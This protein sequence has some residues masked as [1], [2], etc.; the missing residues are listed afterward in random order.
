MLRALSESDRH[1]MEVVAQVL[2]FR[3]NRYVIERLIDH[4]RVPDDPIFRMT[5]PH[6]DMLREEDFATIERL[7][8]GGACAAEVRAAASRIRARLNPHP[9]DQLVQNI[10]APG[11]QHKYRDTVLVFPRQGQTC[12]SYCGYCFRWAQFT[13]EP[14]L[15]I[16]TDETT[17]VA[18][19]VSAHPEVRSVLFTG[20][21][22]M[23]MRTGALRGLVDPLLAIEHVSSVRFGTKSLAYLPHRFTEGEDA[24]ALMR[25]FE[26]IVARGKHL[27]V[28]AHYSHPRE[29]EPPIAQRAL[30]RVIAT[31]ATVRTQAPIVRHVN[32]SPEVWS[33]LWSR[34]VRAGAVPYYMFVERDTGAN[35]YYEVPVARALEVFAEAK[36]LAEGLA[37]TARGPTM[38]C[39]D[40]KVRIVGKTHIDGETKFVLEWIRARDP[41]RVG[42]V[43]FAD[44]DSAATWID[45]LAIVSP[46]CA[47]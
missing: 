6:R 47:S 19:Y 7:L 20:G 13:G 14:A 25:L 36:H 11:I 12:H 32:D 44:Y 33:A 24:D 16:A 18:D 23:V 8:A 21:D 35:R 41:A 3:V 26:S 15:R 34:Q 42:T 4:A 17:D 27:A 1:A 38:S 9:A 43:F 2:P 10:I 30:R 45:Q 29:L 28:M 39:S 37:R 5:F 22:P 40:G 31:G 46:R